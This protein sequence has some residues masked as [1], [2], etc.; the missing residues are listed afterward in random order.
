MDFKSHFSYKK[1]MRGSIVLFLVMICIL[2]SSCSVSSQSTLYGMGGRAAYNQSLQMTNNEQMLLNLVR[3]RYL[4]TPFFLNVSNVTTQFTY[5]T[6]GTAEIPIPGFTN[7]NPSI[8]GGEV[9]W[10]NQPTIQYT[11]LEGHAFA[12]QLL[13]PI[14]LAT[15]QRV[16]LS[17]WDLDLVFRL[18]IQS[19]D[20]FLNAP[21]ASGPIPEYIPKYQSFFEVT[22]LFRYFQKRSELQI[23]V[24]ISKCPKEHSTPDKKAYLLQIAF[25]LGSKE[26]DQLAGLLSGVVIKN[27]H[28]VL[29]LELG[30]NKKGKIGIMPRSILSC[31]YYLSSGV[32]VPKEDIAFGYA[33]TTLGTEGEAF[34]WHDV[35]GE[36]MRVY[37]SK[38][39]PRRSY[40]S[41]YYKDHWF[42]IRDDDLL[43]KKTFVL[44]LQLY[45]LQSQEVQSAGPVLTLPIG[46]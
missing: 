20:D 28:Y 23:G 44:L 42:F 24:K 12:S 8:L 38:C 32:K 21:E 5:R 35:V 18:A 6:T 26:A 7:D 39:R 30:F 16:I 46:G 19:F 13:S 31:M 11:P 9:F 4:D 3:L 43:S 22:E 14:E 33:P 1:N 25:P 2:T 27:E 40:V 36:L 41:I 17:G 37:C 29:N 45:N 10:Q 15:L 34:D